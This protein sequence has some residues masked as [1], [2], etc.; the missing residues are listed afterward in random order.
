[1]IEWIENPEYVD[2]VQKKNKNFLILFF[3]AGFSSPA[4]RALAEVEQ[5]SEENEEVPVYIVDV[6]KVRGVHKLFGVRNVPTVVALQKSKVTQKIEGV[7][8]AQF[9][10][11]FFAGVHSPHHKPG[12]KTV[13][14][15][16]IVYSGPGCP[17]C[18]TAKAYLRRRGI[19]FREID[20][21]RNQHAA[22]S[23]VRRSGQM[24]VPQ[25]DING[26]LI[27][28]FDRLKIDQF[29]ST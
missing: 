5:F 21:S 6:E 3:Y 10:A 1:M 22:E 8:S 24:A 27:V 17:A 16:V 19:T 4:K 15:R 14:H 26:H 12:T 23:L 7:Q 11:R 9:Y 28:G 29:L 2:Q 13:S 20:I 18:G 25:I